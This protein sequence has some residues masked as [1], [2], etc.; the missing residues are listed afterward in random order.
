M[1]ARGKGVGRLRVG[2]GWILLGYVIVLV[3][4]TAGVVA[5]PFS[6]VTMAMFSITIGAFFVVA[7]AIL[8]MVYVFLIVAGYRASMKSVRR[9]LFGAAQ[10]SAFQSTSES[11][12]K[13]KN[14]TPKP[15]DDDLWDRWIDGAW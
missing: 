12:L 1:S 3:A 5:W 4:A 10:G 15:I 8:V 11:S 14:L 13:H 7:I 6:I 2:P 9:L